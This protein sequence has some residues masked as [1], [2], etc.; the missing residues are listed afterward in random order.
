MDQLR[1]LEDA[2]IRGKQDQSA[3]IYALVVYGFH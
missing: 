2:H 3:L 1:K